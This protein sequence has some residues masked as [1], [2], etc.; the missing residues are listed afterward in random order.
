MTTTDFRLFSFS[1]LCWQMSAGFEVER[2]LSPI[3]LAD[4]KMVQPLIFGFV[5][6]AKESIG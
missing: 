3:T 5:V 2:P 1:Y 6:I 4:G